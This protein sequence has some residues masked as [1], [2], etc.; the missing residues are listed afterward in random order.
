LLE[1]S[2]AWDGNWTSECFVNF[3]WT[4]RNGDRFMVTV[5]YAANQAQCLV[6]LPFT[7][8]AGRSVQ[9]VDR[10]GPARYI[11]SGDEL[12]SR[13]LY[14]DLPAWGYHVFEVKVAE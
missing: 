12:S 3:A 9:L 8:L 1:A 5:N 10:M 4:G 2:P 14:L 13:G 11:R 7:G 6:K